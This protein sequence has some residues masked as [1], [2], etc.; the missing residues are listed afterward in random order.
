MG[1]K[2][3]T[4][5]YIIPLLTLS[6]GALLAAGASHPARHRSAWRRDEKLTELIADVQRRTLTTRP[7]PGYGLQ[8]MD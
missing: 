3:G 5:Q 1:A 4:W 8:I 2:H 6:A 7:T